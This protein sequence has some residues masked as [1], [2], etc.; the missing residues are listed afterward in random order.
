[1]FGEEYKEMVIVKDIELYL[2]CE[3]HVLPFF[4]NA[5]IAYILNGHIV[6][7]SKMPRVVDVLARRLQV[8]EL[9]TGQIL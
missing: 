3:H 8:Q 9:M 5:Y 2:L 7:L 4:G 1:M 6:G